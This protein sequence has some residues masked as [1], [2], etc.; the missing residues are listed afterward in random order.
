MIGGSKK[1]TSFIRNGE[2]EEKSYTAAS[3]QTLYRNLERV[4]GKKWDL[5]VCDETHHISAP[6]YQ[7][8]FSKLLSTNPDL[9]VLGVTATPFRSDRKNLKEFF[10]TLAY[11][12]DI[13]ELIKLGYLVPVRGKL[14]PLPVDMSKL[15]TV[16][17]ETGERDYSLK[18]ISKAFNRDDINKLIVDKWIEEAEGRKTIFYTS[19]LE[20]ALALFAEFEKRGISSGYID[21][22][23][24]IERRREMLRAF[25]EGKIQVLTNMNVLTEGFDDPEVECIAIVRPTKSLNLYAQ[26][27]GRGLRIAPKKE[28]CLILDYTGISRKHTII[29]LPELF[30]IDEETGRDYRKGKQIQVGAVEENGEKAYYPP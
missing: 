10:D 8:V 30:G 28:D 5:V 16:K 6:T 13:L 17:T 15:K 21:G 23:M 14:I 27:V 1:E 18:S 20:H 3:I 4:D 26:I 12:I 9:K 7:A 29:G 25:K 19:S 11:S 2:W 22:R 24:N